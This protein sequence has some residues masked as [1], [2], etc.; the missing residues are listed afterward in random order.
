MK[1][2]H[3]FLLFL[4]LFPICIISSLLTPYFFISVL[5]AKNW[6]NYFI[7]SLFFS[8]AFILTFVSFVYFMFFIR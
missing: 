1:A 5:K 3:V 4:L 2:H 8:L 7:A 6:K